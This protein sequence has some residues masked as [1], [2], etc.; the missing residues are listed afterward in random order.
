MFPVDCLLRQLPVLTQTSPH[1]YPLF[2]W[3]RRSS[4]CCSYCFQVVLIFLQR[5]AMLSTVLATAFLSVCPSVTAG[6]VSKR[7][8]GA[9]F[10]GG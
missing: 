4:I 7:I 9:V 5:A 6:I 2:E 8:D 10:T 3:F 1:K